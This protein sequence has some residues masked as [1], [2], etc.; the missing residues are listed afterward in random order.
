MEDLRLA[1]CVARTAKNFGYQFSSSVDLEDGDEVILDLDNV[2][3]NQVYKT[4][5]NEKFDYVE[6]VSEKFGCGSTVV[7]YKYPEGKNPILTTDIGSN[8]AR[9]TDE[10][11][12]FRC[13][14]RLAADGEFMYRRDSLICHLNMIKGCWTYTGSPDRPALDMGRLAP[15]KDGGC[16]MYACLRP[17]V[18]EEQRHWAVT[19]G[20]TW[21][22]L[23][24]FVRNPVIT[25][26]KVFLK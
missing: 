24:E 5:T 6:R 10:A 18:E 12:K 25:I 9:L 17:I 19:N 2:R 16:D 26:L 1:W 23:H 14:K 20:E 15:S 4:H 13:L 22:Y 8:V 7:R 11:G 21:E 3:H